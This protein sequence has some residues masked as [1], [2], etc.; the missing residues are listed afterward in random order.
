VNGALGAVKGADWIDRKTPEP[1]I[2]I[3]TYSNG[4][5]IVINHSENDY[6]YGDMVIEAMS[7]K[8]VR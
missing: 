4:V 2:A 3:N 6:V 7:Y 8:V 1:G 5:M